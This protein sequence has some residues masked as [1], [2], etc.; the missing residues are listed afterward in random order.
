M[1]HNLQRLLRAEERERRRNFLHME[2]HLHN[3]LYD[4]IR[5]CRTEKEKFMELQRYK[6]KLVRLH[7]TRR[8]QQMLDINTQDKMEDEEPSLFHLLRTIRRR[9][10]RAIHQVRDRD[11]NLVT[12]QHDVA[13][14]FRTYLCQ[15]YGRIDIDH[16]SLRT[17]QAHIQQLDQQQRQP[18][19]NP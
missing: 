14:I 13:E 15:R 10:T 18:S 17:M 1:K 3:C 4:I 7:A 11:G 12:R 5:S 16:N 6:A 19:S 9:N 2:N 8:E